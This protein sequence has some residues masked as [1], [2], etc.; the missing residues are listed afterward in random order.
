MTSLQ[1]K[2]P[3]TQPECYALLGL[4]PG[5]N[6]AQLRLARQI[7]VRHWCGQAASLDVERRRQAKRQV[8]AINMA[9]RKICSENAWPERVAETPLAMPPLLLRS[10]TVQGTML[11]ALS[12]VTALMLA[13]IAAWI[14]ATL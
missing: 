14:V 5:C 2:L 3:E 9:A 1:F 4:E 8:A 12:V 11:A 10:L 7:A 13:G 6:A